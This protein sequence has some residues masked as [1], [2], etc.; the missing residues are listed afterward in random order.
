[1]CRWLA[2]DG[3]SQFLRN[4]FAVHQNYKYVKRP[5]FNNFGGTSANVLRIA[6]GADFFSTF[7][8]GQTKMLVRKPTLHKPMQ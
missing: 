2:Q 7:Q 3:N 1:M 5:F 8:G 6:Y 4:I